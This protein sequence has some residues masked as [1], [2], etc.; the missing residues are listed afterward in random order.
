MA[1]D[2]G[3]RVRRW[4][5][6]PDYLI[7]AATMLVFAAIGMYV[8]AMLPNALWPPPVTYR[9]VWTDDVGAVCPGETYW[10][11]VEV[12]VA[13]PSVVEVVTVFLRAADQAPMPV[14]EPFASVGARA[15]PR[16]AVY[17]QLVEW[18]VPEV[19]PGDYVRVTAATAKY[20]DSVPTFITL[21]F[22][23]MEGCE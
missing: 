23:V 13:S 9:I 6:N 16:E 2:G 20:A 15:Y 19:A 12:E 14:P 4:A 3:R 10:M 11:G 18:T 17:E 1:L 8:A 21:D 7:G 22:S 5:L